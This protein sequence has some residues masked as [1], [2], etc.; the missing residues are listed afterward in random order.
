M[1][2]LHFSVATSRLSEETKILAQEVARLDSELRAERAGRRPSPRRRRAGR[3]R[4]GAGSAAAAAE[5]GE[6]HPPVGA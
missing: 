5:Q 4:A 1:L 6:H 3:R 2:L